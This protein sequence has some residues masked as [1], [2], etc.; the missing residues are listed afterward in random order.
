MS[1]LR[2]FH[3]DSRF[4][5]ADWRCS[6][7]DTALQATEASPLPTIA[8]NRQGVYRR[9]VGSMTILVDPGAA[10][11]YPPEMEYRVS[12]PVPGGD[13]SLVVVL[14]EAALENLRVERLPVG[15]T[16]PSRR[17]ALDIRR[18]EHA[19]REG[20]VLAVSEL[21]VRL[22]GEALESLRGR[23]R[24]ARHREGTPAAHRRA[25]E[26]ARETI[27]ARFAER[28]TL[29]DIARDSGYSATHLCEVF[30]AETGM[31][32]HRYL[33]RLRLLVALEGL[34]GAPSLSRLAYQVGFSSPSH[35]ATAFRREFGHPPSRLLAALGAED[36]ARLR[37]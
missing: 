5:A 36:V 35:F 30:R 11:F 29:D 37:A 27:A 2:W 34:E 14:S 18:A 32:I 17:S 25:I 21:L 7:K 33:N 9:H 6:A 26:R 15:H 23:R 4:Q 8:F 24:D 1:S 22:V 19:A 28:L 12:H 16:L 10:V 13:R 31:T 20:A 3:R